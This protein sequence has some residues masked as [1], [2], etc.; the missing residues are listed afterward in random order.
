MRHGL[1]G[2]SSQEQIHRDGKGSM[3]LLFIKVGFH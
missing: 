1:E 3:D 2:Q